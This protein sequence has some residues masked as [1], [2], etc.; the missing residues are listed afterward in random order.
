MLKGRAG[1]LIIPYWNGSLICNGSKRERKKTDW[2]SMLID[3]WNKRYIVLKLS[4]MVG[5][6]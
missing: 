3:G 5:N 1:L 2:I 6:S 4:E